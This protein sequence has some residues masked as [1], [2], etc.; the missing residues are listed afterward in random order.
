MLIVFALFVQDYVLRDA[1]TS[2]VAAYGAFK[3]EREDCVEHNPPV[4]VLHYASCIAKVRLKWS[5]ADEKVSILYEDNGELLTRSY[6]Y[7]IRADLPDTCRLGGSHTA[8]S[9]KPSS[10]AA[11]QAG[12]KAFAA[13]LARCS[14]IKIE[15]IAAYEAEFAAAAPDYERATVGLRSVAS[16]MFKGLRRCTRLKSS[17]RYGPDAT[18]I[19]TRREG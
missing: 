11:W 6:Q 9:A 8:Y 12:A 2:A 18:V 7:P 17:P 14:V 5:S 13:T 4:A 15:Q 1:Q 3:L 16:S 19:C 10:A